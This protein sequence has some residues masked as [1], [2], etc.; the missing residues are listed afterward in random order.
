MIITDEAQKQKTIL[1]LTELL[2][3]AIEN[4]RSYQDQRA[5][6]LDFVRMTVLNGDPE[7]LIA[8]AISNVLRARTGAV[9]LTQT[10]RVCGCTERFACSEGCEWVA[11]DLCSRCV[12]IELP[13]FLRE[14]LATPNGT[15]HGK[16]DRDL[17]AGRSRKSGQAD[18]G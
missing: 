5:C 4:A 14:I 12:G 9:L 17:Q 1:L 6:V 11:D 2:M 8:T 16:A 13:P 3:A 10:C 7:I 18:R 15:S